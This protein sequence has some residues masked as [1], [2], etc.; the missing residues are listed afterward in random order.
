MNPFSLPRVQ[1]QQAEQVSYAMRPGR[2]G[3]EKSPGGESRQINVDKSETCGR[4]GPGLQN[5]GYEGLVFL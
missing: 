2:G 5:R 4:I 1:L 3:V